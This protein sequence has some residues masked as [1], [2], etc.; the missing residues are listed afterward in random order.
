MRVEGAGIGVQGAGY[1]MQGGGFDIHTCLH[2][3]MQY[4]MLTNVHALTNTRTYP[5]SAHTLIT[6]PPIPHSPYHPLFLSF[7]LLLP[8]QGQDSLRGG[9]RRLLRPYSCMLS[10]R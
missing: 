7:N 3:Y 2:V 6:L 4:K 8:C 9:P 5:Y 10:W 1:K